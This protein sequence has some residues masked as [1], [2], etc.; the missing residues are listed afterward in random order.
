M[1][2]EERVGEMKELVG[3]YLE[4]TK[5]TPPPITFIALFTQLNLSQEE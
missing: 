1:R 4:K 2:D 3:L 5:L